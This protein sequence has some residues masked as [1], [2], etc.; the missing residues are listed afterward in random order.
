MEEKIIRMDTGAFFGLVEA[1]LSY[2]KENHFLPA[3]DRWVSSDEAKR[4]LSVQS[5]TTLQSLR[6]SGQI[7]YSQPTR[8]QILYDRESLIEYIEHHAR[9]KF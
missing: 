7:R 5:S 1:M 3:E 6:D 4:I 8:K 9:E 2:I